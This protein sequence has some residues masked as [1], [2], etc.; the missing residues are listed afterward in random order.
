MA[1]Q[2][3]TSQYS[4]PYIKSAIPSAPYSLQC[5]VRMSYVTMILIIN[6]IYYYTN[7]Q[8]KRTYSYLSFDKAVQS[9]VLV[10]SSTAGVKGT[11]FT[12]CLE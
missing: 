10:L 4:S 5:G 3:C 2:N 11:S 6:D 12:S 9:F 7:W 1:F 8:C